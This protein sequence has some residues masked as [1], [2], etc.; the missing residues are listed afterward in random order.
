ME[1]FLQN[2]TRRGCGKATL[3]RNALA[4]C[5]RL[6]EGQKPC[7]SGSA[8]GCT[9]SYVRIFDCSLIGAELSPQEAESGGPPELIFLHGGHLAAVSDFDWNPLQDSCQWVRKARGKRQN[10]PTTAGRRVAAGCTRRLTADSLREWTLRFQMVASAATDNA[11][12]IWQPVGKR[13]FGEEAQ[14]RASL[15]ARR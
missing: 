4:F 9:D 14:E 8:S 10:G 13:R 12:Q 3:S 15:R 11:L 5:C 7:D 6:Y 2:H 1:S